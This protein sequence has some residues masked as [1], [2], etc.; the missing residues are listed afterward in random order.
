M[1]DAHLHVW[2]RARSSYRWLDAAPEPLRADHD[3]ATGLAAQEPYG[4]RQAVL[5]QADETLDET[6][7]LL[8]LV[9]AEPRLAGAVCY[10]PLED[11]ATVAQQLPA[12]RATPGFVGVRNLTHDRPDP[13]WILGAD[14]RRSLA[15]LE[16]A[17]VPLDYV[18][19]LP[20]HLE[21]LVTLAGEHP[22]LTIVLD[23]LGKPPVGLDG[24]Y[25]RWADQLAEVAA[26]PNV[27]AKVSGIYRTDTGE[28]VTTEQLT[29][30]LATALAAFGPDRLMLG[31]D[32]PVSTVSGGADAT[33]SVLTSTV[34]ALP[35]QQAR[36]LRHDTATRVYGLAPRC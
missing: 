16:A 10:L 32:W 9:A 21:N 18:A 35:Q 20:R 31:S 19:V 8:E 15:L 11:P 24:D 1:I 5:V 6:A 26:R 33:M 7:Y 12:L 2:D 28:A 4:V 23:H 25:L 30:V 22:G 36:A 34:D 29:A 14:Q 17:G 3:L 27:V 13:D